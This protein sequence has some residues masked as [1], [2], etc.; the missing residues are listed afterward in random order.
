MI[1]IL[2]FKFRIKVNDPFYLAVNVDCTKTLCTHVAYLSNFLD[3]QILLL[4]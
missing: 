3:L 4:V 1:V 2:Y